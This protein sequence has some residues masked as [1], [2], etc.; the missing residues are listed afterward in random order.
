M[1]RRNVLCAELQGILGEARS[2]RDAVAWL[3][4]GAVAT[5]PDEGASGLT[6]APLWG[7]VRS[8]RAEHPDRRLQ[9]VDVDAPPAEAALLAKLLSTPAEPE[10]ALRHGSVLAPRLA[11]AGAGAGEPHRFA[12]GGTV[13]ITGGVGELGREVA[14]HL[15]AKH[16]VRHLVLTSRRGL[17]TP[18]AAELVVEL[19]GLGAQTVQVV[20]CDV[21]DRDAVRSVLSAI[22]PEH[23][24]T[25]VFHLA[26]TLD[27]GIVPALTG[28][29]LE[30]VLRPKL[31]GAW[32]LHEL[33]AD[34][35][36]A[37]FVLF[38]SVAGLGSPG[39]ANYAAANVF[40]DGLAAERRHRGLAGQSL[41]WGLWE[42]R[43]T[44]MTAHL[45]RAELMRMHRLGVQA[46]S[47]ELGLALVDAAL[48]RPE[49]VLVPLH[50]DLGVMQ[51]Q[52]GGTEVPAL[53][54]G[55]LRGGLR[56]ASSASG[57]TTSLRARL[58]LLASEGER[59]QALQELAQ[60]EIAAVLGLP[61]A[62]SVAADQP[63]KDLGLELADGDRAA[64]PAVG[65]DRG[66]AADHGRVRL[67]DRAGHGQAP[68]G[69]AL[70][71]PTCDIEARNCSR[72]FRSIESRM[73]EVDRATAPQRRPRIA[74]SARSRTSAFRACR[75]GRTIRGRQFFLRCPHTTGI[76]R[77]RIDLH[78]GPRPRLNTR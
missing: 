22:S 34:Q 39:Q 16:G 78:S 55:L 42:P 56:R 10:L 54:R 57:D 7:L 26:A 25:G 46:L 68:D 71:E 63:L 60:E 19:Q 64:Q 40:L 67:P 36:L 51:R 35:D 23:P 53:Y 59:L 72:C 41:M 1:R 62:A 6:R 20:S 69:E 30:R 73:A 45:G 77:S 75:H 50:L 44:G 43:G 76:R 12:A 61:G 5:G 66:Q 74:S 37:A 18:G 11:R 4:R 15:V 65:A 21:S 47:L 48:S 52:L 38:S 17:A 14:R 3:T 31:D 27:D 13:L 58:A 24:L 70:L 33:T 8:A 49:A 9:L 2:E 32:H 29:R 28:E